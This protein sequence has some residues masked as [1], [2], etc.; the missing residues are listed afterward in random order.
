[1]FRRHDRELEALPLQRKRQARFVTCESR[2][3]TICGTYHDY[4]WPYLSHDGMPPGPDMNL[5]VECVQLQPASTTLNIDAYDSSNNLGRAIH[6]E[7]QR[8]QLRY[9]VRGFS[10]GTYLTTGENRPAAHVLLLVPE[11]VKEAADL[12]VPQQGGDVVYLLR[13]GHWQPY[14]A[15]VANA[16]SHLIR[17]RPD[18]RRDGIFTIDVTGMGSWPTQIKLK[19]S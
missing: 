7:V 6:D 18:G 16:S 15:P 3:A 2:P 4:T 17:V 12:P 9:E 10:G 14:P 19:P 5:T 8:M 13:N 1:M 11:P